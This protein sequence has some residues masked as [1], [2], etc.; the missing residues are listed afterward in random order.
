[1]SEN[2]LVNAMAAGGITAMLYR[3][4][5]GHAPSRASSGDLF[6]LLPGVAWQSVD[7]CS[8]H[9]T[10]CF[11][12]WFTA[13]EPSVA[14]PHFGGLPGFFNDPWLFPQKKKNTAEKVFWPLF[15][16]EKCDLTTLL[17]IEKC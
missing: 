12:L 8:F 1:M 5:P 3:E 2:A 6:S 15:A 17:V 11:F 16:K 9:E 13:K 10:V 4:R 14:T 7:I